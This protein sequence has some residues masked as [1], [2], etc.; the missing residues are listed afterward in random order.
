MKKNSIKSLTEKLLINII[1]LLKG[2]N[3]MVAMVF[4]CRI[5]E[6]KTEFKRVPAKLKSAVA[7]ILINDFALA[8][9]IP[10]EFGGTLKA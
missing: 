4:A 2:D 10:V 9:I 5:V 8:E 6:G 1:L 7:E 3:D